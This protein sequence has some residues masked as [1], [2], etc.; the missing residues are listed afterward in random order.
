MS[1]PLTPIGE[2][3]DLLLDATQYVISHQF[4]TVSTLQRNLRVGF[5]K[6]GW[7]MNLLEEREIVGPSRGSFPRDVF[8]PREHLE[9]TLAAI[10]AEARR[11]RAAA[12]LGRAIDARSHDAESENAK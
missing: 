1:G 12:L 8:V 5:A 10:R 4:A 7:L 9:R 11:E 6:A 2:D 3:L